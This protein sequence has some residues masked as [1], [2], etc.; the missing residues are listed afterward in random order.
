MQ[1]GG[2]SFPSRLRQPFIPIFSGLPINP[3]TFWDIICTENLHPLDLDIDGT[4][5]IEKTLNRFNPV[6]RITFLGIYAEW[7]DIGALLLLWKV[8]ILESWNYRNF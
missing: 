5:P 6:Y 2:L 7:W 8:A 1:D 4:D 3:T